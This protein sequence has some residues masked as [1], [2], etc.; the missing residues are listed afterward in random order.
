MNVRVGIVVSV[1][2]FMSHDV[3]AQTREQAEYVER[4]RE[5]VLSMLSTCDT[6][7]C[8]LYTSDAADE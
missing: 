4:V 2:L 3:V 6:E 8:L 5:C 7:L 1:L